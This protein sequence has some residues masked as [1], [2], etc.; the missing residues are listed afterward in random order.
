MIRVLL[1]VLILSSPISTGAFPDPPPAAATPS[2]GAAY[3]APEKNRVPEP[4]S[5]V[6]PLL[7]AVRATADE[8]GQDRWKKRTTQEMGWSAVPEM[9][10]SFYEEARVQKLTDAFQEGYVE[11]VVNLPEVLIL[12]AIRMESNE[13]AADFQKISIDLQQVLLDGTDEREDSEVTVESEASITL[14]GLDE[15][16]EI[17]YIL[18]VGDLPPSP[19]RAIF[20][21][22]GRHVLS[23]TLMQSALDLD[24]TRAIMTRL[25]AAVKTAAA[26]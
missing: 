2:A 5:A 12:R 6:R 4:G 21:R 14:S 26:A 18:K 25:G 23:L 15:A 16:F 1:P 13:T 24:A 19:H 10:K 22:T 20:A 3:S 9:F 11:V 7:A 8:L 17:R